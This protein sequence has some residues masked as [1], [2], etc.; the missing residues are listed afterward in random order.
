MILRNKIFTALGILLVIVTIGSY[1]LFDAN[2][3]QNSQAMGVNIVIAKENIPEGTIIRSVQEANKY[4]GVKRIAQTDAVPSSIR[5]NVKQTSSEGNILDRIRKT[6]VPEVL[7]IADADLQALV[8]KKITTDIYKNQQVLSIYLSNDLV[9]FEEDER[10]FAV[11]TNYIDSVGAEISKDDYVDLWVHY[12]S[13]H[14]KEGTSEKVI[15]ALKVVKVKGANNE[16][17]KGDSGSVP[18]L[19]IFK[20]SEEQISVVS[21]KM[22]EGSLFLT[23]WGRRPETGPTITVKEKIEE[24]NKEDEGMVI[25]GYHVE[26]RGDEDEDVDEMGDTTI[27]EQEDVENE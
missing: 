1:F 8:N 12:G 4:F 11:P 20:M 6:F 18:S 10:Y 19:V 14:E 21:K 17:L 3:K 7:E 23:K 24:E 2:I 26:E 22:H 27:N 5:V 16:E 13:K 15:E 9:E 25:E